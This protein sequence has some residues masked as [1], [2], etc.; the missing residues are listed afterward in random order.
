[1]DA[2][3]QTEGTGTGF[4]FQ[5]YNTPP[6]PSFQGDTTEKKGLFV[7]WHA[8]LCKID[9]II[10]WVYVFCGNH[11]LA[12]SFFCT[13]STSDSKL[14]S[15]ILIKYWH[16]QYWWTLWLLLDQKQNVWCRLWMTTHRW[17]SLLCTSKVKHGWNHTVHSMVLLAHWNSWTQTTPVTKTITFFREWQVQ[18]IGIKTPHRATIGPCLLQSYFI[19]NDQ[20]V[21]S[22]DLCWKSFCFFFFLCCG[23]RCLLFGNSYKVLFQPVPVQELSFRQWQSYNQNLFNSN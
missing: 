3:N 18:L 2:G 12:G 4:Q 15:C 9:V 8:F 19:W 6:L 11:Y 23:L 20:S 10:H 17:L 13:S 16:P 5:E 22:G 1:M 14:L 21:A 7:V